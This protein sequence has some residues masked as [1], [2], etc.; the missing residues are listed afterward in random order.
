[1]LLFGHF[2]V[3]RVM[4]S[5]KLGTTHLSLLALTNVIVL[6]LVFDLG[7]GKCGHHC[8]FPCAFTHIC[9]DRDKLLFIQSIP[10]YVYR[11]SASTK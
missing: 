7:S 8:V 9:V 2:L 5:C 1:M 10:E 3:E 4:T 6:A 11:I